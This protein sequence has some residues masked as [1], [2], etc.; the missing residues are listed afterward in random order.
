MRRCSFGLSGTIPGGLVPAPATQAILPETRVPGFTG[1]WS[2][3]SDGTSL[4]RNL[5]VHGKESAAQYRKVAH[6]LAV[7]NSEFIYDPCPRVNALNSSRE[8][9]L[10]ANMLPLLR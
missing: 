8:L 10:I 9:H 2:S 4:F 1:L 7:T 5:E 3:N 6:E